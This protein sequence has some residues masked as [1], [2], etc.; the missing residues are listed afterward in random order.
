MSAPTSSNV[1]SLD[2]W[3][4]LLAIAIAVII[5]TGIVGTIPW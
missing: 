5:R 3:A 2:T 1:L 4:V